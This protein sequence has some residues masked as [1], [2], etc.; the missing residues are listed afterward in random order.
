MTHFNKSDR[1]GY[2]RDMFGRI[3][4]QYDLVNR[5][6]SLGRDLRWRRYAIK[7]AVLP[8]A[9][10]LLDVG[11]G[12]GDFAIEALTLDSTLRVTAVDFSLQMM[13]VG[14]SRK[15]G[16]MVL[17]CNA[18]ALRLPFPD[19][20]FDAVIS[21]YL[22]RNVHD[23]RRAFEEQMRVVKPCGRVVC[24]DT[25]PVPNKITRIPV[26]LYLKMVI[27]LLGWLITRDRAAYTYLYKSTQAFMTP[28][29]LASTM[30]SAGLLNVS[31]Q[32]FMFGTM[33]LHTGIRPVK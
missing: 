6:I 13:T 14:R 28:E 3:S 15:D 4:G 25:V 33:A 2:I 1:T 18:D 22:I 27:P 23:A 31:H 20:V 30:K 11:T 12:T 16:R 10:R 24:L 19:A 8:K 26:M 7:K 21:G 29:Q 17:W 9:G 5:L 32:R